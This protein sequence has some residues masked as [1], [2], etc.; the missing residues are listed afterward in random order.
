MQYG[1]STEDDQ[2]VPPSRGSK[3]S[4][5]G[6]YMASVYNPI[7]SAMKNLGS[8]GSG[9]SSLSRFQSMVIHLVYFHEEST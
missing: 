4:D 1:A 8:L 2:W 7:F 5:E 3:L 9:L 6:V